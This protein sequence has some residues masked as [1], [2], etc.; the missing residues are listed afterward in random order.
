MI[1]F[2][3]PRCSAEIEVPEDYA[4]RS[5]NC[6]TCGRKI[7]VP[8]GAVP[9]DEGPSEELNESSANVIRVEG[10]A[11]QVR[12]KL[13]GLLIAATAVLVLSPVALVLTGWS[14]QG[15][16]PWGVAGLCG[17]GVAF[18]GLLLLLA[19]H[20]N[21]RR[22]HGRKSGRRFAF[23]ILAGGVL[24]LVASLCVALVAFASADRSSSVERLQRIA[25][26]LAEHAAR[27]GGA[28]PDSPE[29]LV[30]LNY[31]R[32]STLTSHEAVD[33]RAG[34]PTY[35]FYDRRLD[36]RTAVPFPGDLLVYL[37][38]IKHEVKQGQTAAEV[39]FAVQLDGRIVRV[40]TSQLR[41]ILRQQDQAVGRVQMERKNEKAAEKA[42]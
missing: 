12:P 28:L 31:I 8:A 5:A 41:D 25:K 18:F 23:V 3:C 17:A 10:R 1:V 29:T 32:P 11:Y 30:R 26:A 34:T 13:E 4:G 7:Q 21:I 39:Y 27:N 2:H 6:P 37:D 38:G 42:K 9:R 40:P 16:T 35:S 24:L 19:A 20:Y 15:Y 22:S 36:L 33:L 14:A